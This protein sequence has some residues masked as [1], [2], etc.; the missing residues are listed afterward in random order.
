M[1]PGT[2]GESRRPRGPLHHRGARPR[3]GEGGLGDLAHCT[4]ARGSNT[5]GR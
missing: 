4:G 1:L 3:R 2:S 5:L